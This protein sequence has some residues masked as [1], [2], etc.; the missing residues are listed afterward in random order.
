MDK[1]TLNNAIGLLG[2]CLVNGDEGAA[3]LYAWFCGER[4]LISETIKEGDFGQN[5]PDVPVPKVIN[6]K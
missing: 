6:E 5:N 4:H 2:E 3:Q 1:I